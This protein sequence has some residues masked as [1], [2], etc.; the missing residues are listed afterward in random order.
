MDEQKKSINEEEIQL[1]HNDEVNANENEHENEH[2]NY[3][4]I[5]QVDEQNMNN[6]IYNNDMYSDMM[7]PIM[8]PNNMVIIDDN[9]HI[10]MNMHH[11]N[12]DMDED[13]E[14]KVFVGGLSWETTEDSMRQYFEKFGVIKN[15]IIMIDK[16]TGH[17]RGFGFIKMENTE[18]VEKILA[19]EQHIIDKKYVDVKRAL[20]QSYTNPPVNC[21]G[22]YNYNINNYNINNNKPIESKKIF[23]GG[24]PPAVTEEEFSIYFKQYGNIIEAVIMLDRSTN[25]SRGFGF[26]TYET[27]ESVTNVL[28]SKNELMG[29]FVEVKRAEP[30]DYNQNTHNNNMNR[31]NGGRT[32]IVNNGVTNRR[33]N[34]N[35]RGQGRFSNRGG[36]NGPEIIAYTNEPIVPI[37]YS[38]HIN[39]GRGGRIGRN[40]IYRGGMVPQRYFVD[41]KTAIGV[42]GVPIIYQSTYPIQGGSAPMPLHFY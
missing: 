4:S 39:A 6:N 3:G 42:D 1:T 15:I 7:Y 34:F 25:R 17:S 8:Y 2:E 38:G 10:N 22:N 24:L 36:R 30:K 9:Y 27:E 33:N 28:S 37:V 31:M 13:Y 14:G 40:N 29:K 20:P 32:M 19:V 16:F 18:S 41:A 23:V 26:I 21:Y 12:N 11:F 5:E 35:G